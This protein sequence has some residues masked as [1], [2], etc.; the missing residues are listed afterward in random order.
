MGVR[1]PKPDTITDGMMLIDGIM[2]Y[3]FP[4]R[5]YHQL[6]ETYTQHWTEFETPM[7]ELGEGSKKLKGR[8]T[9]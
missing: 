8:A 1:T 7:F 6:T 5:P 3:L 9:P 2:A 4:K